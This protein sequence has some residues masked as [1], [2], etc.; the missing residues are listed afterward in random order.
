M[1]T[2]D[3]NCFFHASAFRFPSRHFPWPSGRDNI[4]FAAATAQGRRP[5]P[6]RTRKLRPGT[7]M[8][9]HPIGCGRVARRRITLRRETRRASLFSC[10]EPAAAN[11]SFFRRPLGGPTGRAPVPAG[12]QPPRRP[13]PAAATPRPR[14]C[15]RYATAGTCK[16][17]PGQTRG[18]TTTATWR[19]RARDARSETLPSFHVPE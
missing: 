1:V 6:F 2:L 3:T 18:R 10:P 11:G 19:D 15:H 8:V 17:S 14:P 16:G 13:A 4:R 5:V 7:A 12:P 9:L